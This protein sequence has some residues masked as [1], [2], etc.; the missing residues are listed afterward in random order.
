VYFEEHGTKTW[1]HR[2]MSSRLIAIGIH[3]PLPDFWLL[4]NTLVSSE[5]EEE[6]LWAW[7][8]TMRA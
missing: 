2:V 1:A 7:S 4:G 8:A 6:I 3:G 5:L